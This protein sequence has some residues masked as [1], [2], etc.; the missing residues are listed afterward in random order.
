MIEEEFPRSEVTRLQRVDACWDVY[1]VLVGVLCAQ[2]VERGE[3]AVKEALGSP[4][5]RWG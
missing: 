4:R 2:A 5:G 1:F 3:G